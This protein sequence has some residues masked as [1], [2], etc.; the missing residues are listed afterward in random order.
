M[1]Y[2]SIHHGSQTTILTNMP[3]ADLECCSCGVAYTIR[4]TPIRQEEDVD[5]IEQDDDFAEDLFPERC[6]FCGDTADES[7]V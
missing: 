6:P 1:T 3:K 4:W 7:D 2:Q 5:P